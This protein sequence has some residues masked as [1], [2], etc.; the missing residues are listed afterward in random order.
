MLKCGLISV[1]LRLKS[2][3]VR[4]AIVAKA[5]GS[6]TSVKGLSEQAIKGHSLSALP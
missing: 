5:V 1:E 2:V 4:A 6:L 3:S